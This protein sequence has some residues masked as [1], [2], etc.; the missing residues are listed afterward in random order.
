MTDA[1]LVEGE[2]RAR[3]L[4]NRGPLRFDGNG[5]LRQEIV[6]AYWR[7][8]FYVFEGVVGD[9]ELNELKAG[10]AHLLERAPHARGADTD[11]QGRPALGVDLERPQFQ[12]AKPLS[13]PAGGTAASD[14]R[15]PVKMTEPEASP[16][17]PEEVLSFVGGGALQLMDAYLRLRID[18]ADTRHPITE[19]IASWEMGDETYTMADA[20]EGSE[21]L[22]TTAHAKSMRTIGWTREH[23]QA[24]VFCF[25]SG[26]DN[27]TWQ[28]PGF[29]QVL[30]RG[31]HWVSRRI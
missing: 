30:Q 29:R 18:V 15:H 17:A 19:G 28:E 4:G 27:Q 7:T 9:E 22:L 14:G 6:D 2:R 5:T 10:F 26:H 12:F 25:Q 13:D 20:Q 23:K 1:Y 16:E 21:I 31:I 8:G 3:D 24:R 11:A